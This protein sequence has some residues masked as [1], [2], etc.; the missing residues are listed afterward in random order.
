MRKF[1][2]TIRGCLRAGRYTEYKEAPY[3]GF[4]RHSD[5]Y[6]EDELSYRIFLN[7]TTLRIPMKLF[8]VFIGARER[9]FDAHRYAA[10]IEE[11]QDVCEFVG[12]SFAVHL[13]NSFR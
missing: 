11:S 8:L 7:P 2:A 4:E 6:A 13:P 12:E 9:E 10:L 1:A 3:D 5:V